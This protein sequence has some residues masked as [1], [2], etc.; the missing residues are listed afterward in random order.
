MIKNKSI[1]FTVD[2]GINRKKYVKLLQ[3][4]AT[5][6][7]A[8]FRPFIEIDTFFVDQTKSVPSF[9]WRIN[10]VKSSS[11]LSVTVAEAGKER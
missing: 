8:V 5:R 3:Q 7:D 4:C 10:V 11:K 2:L 1:I 9:T 6:I